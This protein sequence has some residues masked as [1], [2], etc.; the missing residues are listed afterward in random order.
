[1]LCNIKPVQNARRDDCEDY[2]ILDV[3]TALS[4]FIFHSYLAEQCWNGGCIYLIMLRR[5]K[6]KAPPP[7]C[8]GS[9]STVSSDSCED[10]KQDRGAPEPPEGPA[11][12]KRTRKF[13]VISRS[14]FNRGSTDSDLQSCYNGSSAP[15]DAGL[16]PPGEDSGCIPPHHTPTEESPDI[17]SVPQRL[18]RGTATLPARCHSQLLEYKMESFSSEPSGQPREG[19]LIWKMHMVKGEE[20]LG[21]Q[22]TGG[23]GSKRS[24]HGIII[25]RVEKAG[26]IHRDGR[27]HAGDELLMIN[28]QS[29]VGLTHQEAVG[30]LRSTSGLVQLVEEADV[31]FERFPS[32]S[33]PDLVSTCSSLSCPP[34]TAP[35]LSPQ[36]SNCSTDPYLTNMEKVEGQ[37]ETEAPRGSCWSPTTT[38]ICSRA[39]GGGTR[40]ESVGEDDELLVENGVSSCEVVEKP[41]PGRRK[42]SLPQQLDS[43]GVRQEYQIIKKS[44]RSLSTIQVESPWRLAQPSIISSIVLMKGQG[45]GLGF[46]IVGGQDSA[47][48]Q[49]GIFVKTIF[50]HG[51]AA[52]DGR[53]KEGDE[54][55]EV[56]GESLQGLTHQQAIQ[57]FKQLK[58]GVVT[59][60]IR[61]RLRSPSLTPCLTPTLLSRSSSPNSTSNTS[62]G[63]TPIPPAFEEAEGHRGPGPGP[64]DCI[65]MEVTLNKEPA[66]GLGIGVCCLTLE[67]SSP[68]IYIHNLALGSVAKMDS[69]LSRGDQILEVDS[70]SLR[71]AALSEAYAILS[72]CGPGPVSL[73]ISRHPNPKVSEQEMDQMIARST[74]RDKM[75]K[76]PSSQS[77]GPSCKSPSPT[78]KERQGDGSP[79]LSWTMKRFLEPASRQGSLSSETELSQYFSQD[80]SSH[81]FLSESV[82]TASNSE[83]ALHQQSCSTS[84]ED[85]SSRPHEVESVY[86]ASPEK[87]PVPLNH[88]VEGVCQPISVSSPTSVRSPLLRQR[89]VMCFEDVLSDEEDS[90]ITRSTALLH[91]TTRSVPFSEAEAS[92]I[93]KCDSA[94]LIAASS[95]DINGNSEDDGGLQRCGSLEVTTPLC[96][97]FSQCEEALTNKSESP[98]PESPLMLIR[99]AGG[100]ICTLSHL[101]INSENYTNP[102]DVQLE[103][104][105]SPKLEHKAITRVKSMMSIEAPS[106]PQQQR[107]KADEPPPGIAPA[108]SPSSAPLEVRNP[109]TAGGLVPHQHCKKGDAGELVGVCTID[110][111]SLRRSEDESF[112]LDLEI[113][114]SPL[115]VLIAGLKPGGAAERESTGK[116]CPGDEI[117]SFGEKLVRS[118]TYEELCELMHNLPV[119]LSLDI[120]RAVSAVDRLSSLMMSSGSSDGGPTLYPARCVQR[121]S[122]EGQALSEH[123]GNS[124]HTAQTDH[125]VQIPITNIDDI[126]SEVSPRSDTHN[127]FP[128]ITSPDEP[129]S[130]CSGPQTVTLSQEAII[131]LP[132]QSSPQDCC[133]LEAGSGQDAMPPVETTHENHLSHL[134]PPEAGSKCMYPTGDDSDSSTTDDSVMVSK[135]ADS[136]GSLLEPSSDEEEVELFSFNAQQPASDGLCNVSLS[137]KGSSTSQHASCPNTNLGQTLDVPQGSADVSLTDKDNSG[138]S[139]QLS[140]LLGAS[141]TQP[142]CQP[143]NS[144][145][146]ECHIRS[147]TEPCDKVQAG[148][149]SSPGTLSTYSSPPPA[150]NHSVIQGTVEHLHPD[151]LLTSRTFIEV[152]LSPISGSSAPV[153]ADHETVNP[154]D[155]QR[156]PRHRDARSAAMLPP[157]NSTVDKTSSMTPER[158]SLSTEAAMSADFNPFSVRHKIKSFENLANFDRPAAKSTDIQSYAL[159]YRASLNQRIA[160]YMGV[161][162][163]R[164]HGKLPRSRVRQLRALSMPELEKLSTEDFTR[165]HGEDGDTL[166]PGSYPN[167]PTIAT[168]SSP[169][170]ATLTEAEVTGGSRTDPGSHEETPGAGTETQPPSW[171][172]SLKELSSSPERRCKLQSL[173]PPPPLRSYVSALLQEA[174]GLPQVHDNTHLVVLSKEEGSGLGFSI[175]GGVDLEQK[176]ITVHRVFTK[177]TASLEGTIQRGDSILSINGISLGGKTHGETVSCLHQ[178][179][180]SM[181][182]LVVIWR[183]E[184]GELSS[185]TPEQPTRNRSGGAG[186]ADA[187]KLCT[188]FLDFF[189]DK[190]NSIHQELQASAP[191][192]PHATPPPVT[193]LVDVGPGGAL[194][195]ELHK[196]STGLGFSL[197]GGESSSQ[198]DRPLLVKR[199]FKGGAAELSGVIQVGDEVVSINGCSLEGLMHHDAWRIIKATE[200]GPNLL[201]FRRPSTRP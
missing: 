69:R 105:R 21:I 50:P 87:P 94:V 59:L 116:L 175:A 3:M 150:D 154:E 34:Q 23:R 129:V 174:E 10:Q 18:H 120:K 14:S 72:E 163:R 189:E 168:E 27:L 67:N 169:P 63:G 79:A 195:V 160:G 176:A 148:V 101:T 30:I 78:L 41:P 185:D 53:L 11:N 66:V 49:M 86:P 187:P 43:A 166:D 37:S 123:S 82:L 144:T 188:R 114:S 32:T 22:I 77:Q 60:T 107:S 33:L 106:P 178:A 36:T 56:N 183:D 42:H 180:L 159:A 131:Q 9:V 156:S 57:T 190:V 125:D 140:Q 29:L 61:T 146:T 143:F 58:R 47:R 200:E 104:K 44:A 51:A 39:Q 84:L 121:T 137:P 71:H 25:A 118:S 155:S 173:L 52:A 149:A 138:L 73:I 17:R 182:A 35:P 90:I 38:K 19:S 136:S 88:H 55:L 65:I 1:M 75:K 110:T 142:P 108:Q 186:A 151:A 130:C 122:D 8:N 93:S 80:A 147:A 134:E 48:G 184:D 13:G 117:V 164:K 95:L 46:S 191:S 139:S 68:G 83:E 16:S 74:N 171:S 102:D 196:T 15:P 198:G 167:I 153:V 97:S 4:M 192:D 89:R 194:T 165:G 177:G 128:Y 2:L 6:R 62:G 54:V 181:Q 20:G 170:A 124:N 179:R 197:E 141:S 98:G 133:I 26:A 172:I 112:G 158:R 119:T 135:M 85:N 109:K 201:L 113:M 92:D 145:P 28:G 99:K 199:V 91:R 100:S 76:R 24:P 96:G 64:K 126:L 193:V 70:V 103:S 162:L 45:K 40:L 152:R 31:G 127:K 115:K 157:A 132:T 81:S 5:V 7:P 111:V 12:C 161:V